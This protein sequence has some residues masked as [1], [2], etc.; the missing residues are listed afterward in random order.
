M[1]LGE[2]GG[3]E[4]GRR[5]GEVGGFELLG[6]VVLLFFFSSSSFLMIIC[7]AS[8]ALHFFFFSDFI[9][10][11]ICKH[12]EGRELHAEVIH[13]PEVSPEISAHLDAWKWIR[14]SILPLGLMGKSLSKEEYRCYFAFN[15]TFPSVM[16]RLKP[17]SNTWRSK[18]DKIMGLKSVWA[19]SFLWRTPGDV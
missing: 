9:C 13:E 17:D 7:T 3:G 14:S 16:I 1:C 8:P 4:G 10:M 5:R 2:R 6:D 18:R 11:Q 15:V 19:I 12:R